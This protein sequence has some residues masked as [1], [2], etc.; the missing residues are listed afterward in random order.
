MLKEKVEI[1]LFFYIVIDIF[2]I[3]A[4]FF[5]SFYIRALF[6]TEIEIRA[7]WNLGSYL[8]FLWLV[9]PLWII[10]LLFE[11]A[12]FSLERKNFRELILPTAKAVFEG[13][14][15]ILTVLFF[16]KIFAKSRLFFVI[17]GL[18]NIS[19][20]LLI[21]WLISFT[22]GR[23]FH[24]QLFY[25]SVLMV[26]AGKNARKLSQFFETH[27]QWGIRVEGFVKVGDE[28]VNVDK[29][30]VIG[31]FKELSFLLRSL[32]ID[33]VIFTLP[34]EKRELIMEG[35]KTCK[36]LG[37][38]ASCP[39]TDFFPSENTF[40]SLEVYNNIPLLSFRATTVRKW[41]LL[42]K[43]LFDRFFS[44]FLCILLLPLFVAVA[45]LIKLGSRGPVFFKQ[46]RCGVNG[47]R[48][49]FYKFRTMVEDAEKRKQEVVHLNVKKIVFKITND[50]RITRIGKILRK[51]SIDELPQLFNVLKGDMSFV[52]PRPPI[53]EE[54]ELYEDWQRRR[55]SM[56]PG[57]TCLWQV[58]GR[59]EVDFD[60]WMKLD[61]EYID[62]WSVG[63]D[64]KILCRTVPAIL[65][66]KGAF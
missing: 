9:I 10:L 2:V 58:K 56:K 41:E 22:Q 50:P 24:K 8:W 29:D 35:I 64:I 31:S 26:G 18:F 12:Y 65:T 3:I 48:F 57:L 30:R 51:T 21:R 44:F 36:K 60:E 38:L 47:R 34:F 54:V 37:V 6:F 19:F 15:I 39:I 7:A 11:K 17:F 63:F 43:G 23:L 14:L 59:A 61:L 16:A 42:V 46:V 32:P 1:S 5:V 20:L 66:T 45:I 40:F 33:W 25:H 4:S 49:T 13:L 52:G 53:P 55:L 27:S 28:T 62:N